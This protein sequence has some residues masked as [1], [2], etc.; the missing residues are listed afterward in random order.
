MGKLRSAL[1]CVTVSLT[2]TLAGS[3]PLPQDNPGY[4]LRVVGHSM[5]GGTAALLTTIL[6]SSNNPAFQ[7]ATCYAIACPSCMTAELAEACSDY[8]TT[9]VHGTDVVPTYS[10]YAS[11]DLRREVLRSSWFPEFRQ[12]MTGRIRK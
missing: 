11:D 6:R 7:A 9:L 1:Y 8:V 5:G 10:A 3:L 4:A 12:D 2:P